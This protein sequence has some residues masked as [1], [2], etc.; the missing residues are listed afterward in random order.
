MDIVRLDS[1]DLLEDVRSTEGLKSP[2]L[3]LPEALATMLGLPPEGLLRDERVGTDGARVHLVIDHVTELEEVGHPNGRGLVEA[4]T[5]TP[6]VEVGLTVARQASLVR[7]G[8]HIIERST[9]EDRCGELAV[10]TTTRPSQDGLEDLTEVHSR[11]HPERVEAEVHRRTILEEGHILLAD[12][13]GDNTLIP[14]TTSHLIP[15]LDLTLLG[16]VD[17]GHLDNPGG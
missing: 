3:H 6:V 13:L 12:D 4:L 15:D 17:L 8:V 16:D 5:G 10:Q 14:V 11:R 7:P 1:Q 9:V 2:Y